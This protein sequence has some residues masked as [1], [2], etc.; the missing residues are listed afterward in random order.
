MNR[1]PNLSTM[2]QGSSPPKDETQEST[3]QLDHQHG[4]L[5]T[6]RDECPECRETFESTDGCALFKHIAASSH[7]CYVCLC[8]TRFTRA[9]ALN[10][11]I[12][13]K[14]TDSGMPK[15]PCHRC[16]RHQGKNGFRRQDHLIQHLRG[17]HKVNQE[18]KGGRLLPT[19][20]HL[21]CFGYRE[22][23]FHLMPLQEQMETK[24]FE[25]R[26]QYNKHLRI[27]HQETPFP[28]PVPG[29]SK[30]GT[31]GLPT[32]KALRTHLK[33]EHPDLYSSLSE[34]CPFPDCEMTFLPT[35]GQ[36]HIFG[37]HSAN[38]WQF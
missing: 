32:A 8:G 6:G 22:P 7:T 24:P 26:T 34:L 35:E 19:C 4:R 31:A 14:S 28:C 33:S 3:P 27:I 16:K 9:D 23:S 30:S 36:Y 38:P 37:H 1:H 29:C 25:N 18:L 2:Q 20:R 5:L 13:S 12:A 11:H 15:Y 10:R 21:D 17:Y